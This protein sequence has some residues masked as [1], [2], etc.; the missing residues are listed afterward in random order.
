VGNRILTNR[1]NKGQS[2]LEAT[3][4]LVILL[5]LL[6]GIIRIWLWENNQIVERQ[7]RYN[8]TRVQAGSDADNYQL[9]WPVHTPSSIGDETLVKPPQLG[10]G[11]SPSG[12]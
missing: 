8:Q 6:G 7:V 2:L 4:A 1:H 9:V 5:L 12:E 3:F 10:E 11:I